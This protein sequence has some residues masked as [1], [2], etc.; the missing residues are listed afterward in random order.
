L[1]EAHLLDYSEVSI[2]GSDSGHNADSGIEN[3]SIQI[4]LS[5]KTIP[6]VIE[7]INVTFILYKEQQ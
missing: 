3:N 1:R 6:V 7:A 4:I 2:Y 5:K